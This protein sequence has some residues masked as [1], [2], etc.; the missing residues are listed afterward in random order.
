M[1][2]RDSGANLSPRLGPQKPSRTNGADALTRDADGEI[3]RAEGAPATIE[4]SLEDFIARA[5][6]SALDAEGWGLGADPVADP[7][8][9]AP[10]DVVPEPTPAAPSTPIAAEHVE[11][12]SVTIDRA[13][14]APA[15]G[16]AETIAT[17]APRSGG[18][19]LLGVAF[20]GGLVVMSC[21]TRETLGTSLTIRAEILAKIL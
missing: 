9:V 2:E 17:P 16:P 8:P 4:Q 10:I 5:N 13:E 19:K 21:T 7:T 6:A 18:W 15:R 11:R 20:A 1:P 3:D 14:G 12:A